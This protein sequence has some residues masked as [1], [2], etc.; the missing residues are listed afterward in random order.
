V[1]LIIR[2]PHHLNFCAQQAA[3]LSFREKQKPEARSE[4]TRIVAS[5]LTPG[6]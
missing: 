4:A 2:A 3:A 6:F 5:L 1:Y